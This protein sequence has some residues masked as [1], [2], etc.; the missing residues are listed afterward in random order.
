[1]TPKKPEEK[2]EADRT[3]EDE[4]DLRFDNL[5]QQESS[6]SDRPTPIYPEPTSRAKAKNPSIVSDSEKPTRPAPDLDIRELFSQKGPSSHPTALPP[7]AVAKEIADVM[8]GTHAG[9]KPSPLPRVDPIE[10]SVQIPPLTMPVPISDTAPEPSMSPKASPRPQA[11]SLGY[12]ASPDIEVTGS[13]EID[14][15]ELEEPFQYSPEQIDELENSKNILHQCLSLYSEMGI[16]FS[17]IYK[18]ATRYKP[19]GNKLS[20]RQS[21]HVFINFLRMFTDL[22]AEHLVAK[23]PAIVKNKMGKLA[24]KFMLRIATV[25]GNEVIC[26]EVTQSFF[27]KIQELIKTVP[28]DPSLDRVTRVFINQVRVRE[29]FP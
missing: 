11:P 9:L 21:T 16:N 6:D 19:N 29:V 23:N 17:S 13:E 4:F 1:M 7:N 15:S 27:T 5:F 2:K 10:V 8:N 3:I 22:L 26:D 24:G 25:E 14:L 18:A 12:D 28:R 20:D